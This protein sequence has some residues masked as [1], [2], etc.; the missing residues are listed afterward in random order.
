MPHANVFPRM[1]KPHDMPL[2]QYTA[3]ARADARLIAAAPE[4]LE[5]AEMVA[6]D[7][8]NGVGNRHTMAS[9]LRAAI[10]KAAER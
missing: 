1:S 9:C 3:Q 7:L 8:E 2:E 6:V 10:A 4:L 5:A